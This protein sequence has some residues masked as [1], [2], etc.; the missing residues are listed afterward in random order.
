M[1][2]EPIVH[3]GLNLALSTFATYDHKALLFYWPKDDQKQKGNKK[4]CG[5][6][7]MRRSM[8]LQMQVCFYYLDFNLSARIGLLSGKR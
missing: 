8:K 6:D 7:F 1:K 3:V 4:R 5:C 2:L